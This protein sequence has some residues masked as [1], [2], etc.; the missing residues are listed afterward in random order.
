MILLVYVLA[1]SFYNVEN[2]N[3]LYALVPWNQGV[4]H[5]DMLV[6][7]LY[8][9][10]AL[11]AAAGAMLLTWSIAYRPATGDPQHTSFSIAGP[12]RYV[13]YPHYWA[14]FCSCSRWEP[15]RAFWD[16]RSCFSGRLSF[17]C[18]SLDAKDSI[19]NRS[20]VRVSVVM[21]RAFHDCCLH[22]VR[23]LKTTGNL[24]TGGDLFGIKP[25]SGVLS[26]PCWRSRLL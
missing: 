18:G 25:F 8:A 11:L 17:C 10:A 26:L 13:R 23:A 14:Y 2:L 21:R 5:R 6:R 24:R 9:G 22:F 4:P 15:S 3:V 20:T 19:S 16:F 12:F 7:Y 1:Y